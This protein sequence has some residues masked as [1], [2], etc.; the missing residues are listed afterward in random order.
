MAN[1]Q[2][3]L[4]PR[5]G[6]NGLLALFALV[7]RPIPEA[8]WVLMYLVVTSVWDPDEGTF[9]SLLLFATLVYFSVAIGELGMSVLLKWLVI[10]RYQAG[11]V[12]FLSAYHLK[13]MFMMILRGASKVLSRTMPLQ[14]QGQWWSEERCCLSNHR[15]SRVR[16]CQHG[17]QA[18]S[19]MQPLAATA[20]VEQQQKLYGACKLLPSTP[21]MF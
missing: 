1:C 18:G 8:V 2:L 5:K 6:F 21:K 17:R 12:P 3:P 19:A 20:N 14:C 4:K 9:T 11:D 13:W 10:G 15:S 7:A 16:L